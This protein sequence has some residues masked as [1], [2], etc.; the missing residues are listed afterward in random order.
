MIRTQA[1]PGYTLLEVLLASAIA[2][3]LLGGLYVA[4]DITLVRMDVTRG[5]VAADDLSRAVAD[6]MTADLGN[7]LGPLPPKSGGESAGATTSGSYSAEEGEASAPASGAAA[8]AARAPA[9]STPSAASSMESSATPAAS[10]SS[11]PA[12]AAPAAT[13]LPMGMGVVGTE[14]QLTVFCSRVPEV[15]TDS[16]AAASGVQLPADL[17]RVTY[18]LAS[19]GSGLCRQ[20]RPWV[21]ADGVGNATEPDRTDEA[22]DLLAP[23]VKQVAFEYFDGSGWAGQWD[24]A[25]TDLDGVALT[26]PPRAVRVTLT[27]EL[28]GRGTVPT[29][30]RVTHTVALRA[31]VGNAQPP[32]PAAT[33][34]PTPTGSN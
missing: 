14:N 2:L 25:V 31:A 22:R 13:L 17:V 16:E 23:E 10:S 20:E 18:Y 21:T 5:V 28:P 34:T 26:G 8:P 27:L 33:P 7:A 4:M 15:L 32:E 3:I 9:A 30:K 24:G 11:E 1:R 19:D 29:Q 6:R 12:T